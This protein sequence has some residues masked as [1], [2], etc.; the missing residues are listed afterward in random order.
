MARSSYAHAWNEPKN[1]LC[2]GIVSSGV[3]WKEHCFFCICLRDWRLESS[4]SQSWIKVNQ[5]TS[6]SG[7]LSLW[8]HWN[9]YIYRVGSC[10]IHGVFRVFFDRSVMYKNNLFHR[11][12]VGQLF[13]QMNQGWL[14]N[15]LLSVGSF[16]R[17]RTRTSSFFL[18]SSCRLC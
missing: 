12:F 2:C 14:F 9:K 11:V 17:C 15:L 4:F 10:G 6:V 7:L 13:R 16:F 1:G 18:P 5:F 8:I 3:D